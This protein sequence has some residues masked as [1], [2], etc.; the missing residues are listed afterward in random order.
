MKT[1]TGLTLVATIVLVV[2][3]QGTAAGTT[4]T[5]VYTVGALTVPGVNTGLV[6][7]KGHPV[8]VTATGTFCPGT[9]SCFGPD[10]NPAV[11]TTQS[12]FG[13]FL[14]PGAPAYGLVGRVGTGPWVQVGSGPTTLSG[15]GVLVFAVNDDLFGDNTGG[16]TATVSYKATRG[17]SKDCYPGWGYGDANHEH[18]GPPGLANKPASPGHSSAETH[19]SS[20]EHGSA[21]HGKP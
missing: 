20:N 19:G 10:G 1:F 11:D 13:G 14:L 6:L 5:S 12:D 15:E 4:T 9:G 2:A 3:A 7:K 18:C 17:T 16:F 21:T 8:T